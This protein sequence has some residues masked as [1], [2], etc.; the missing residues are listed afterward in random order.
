MQAKNVILCGTLLAALAL[1]A[2]A[3]GDKMPQ[4]MNIRAQS[5]S[6]DEFA[7]L[8]TKPLTMPEDLK[9]LPAPTPGGSNITA[10]T[11]EADAI[12]AL[13]GNPDAV[14]VGD[15]IAAANTGLVSYAARFG[16]EA[17]I[18]DRL[19]QEDLV[20][21]QKHNGRLLER[22]FNINAYFKA[23]Q[24]MMLDTYAELDRWRA[25]GVQTVGAPPQGVKAK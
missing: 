21:R 24:P 5:R 11:P 17:G 15:K 10:P 18:R 9:A 3:R 20:W 19:A 16:R 7:I 22:V 13:G 1:S 12:A 14:K 25:A 23:Y 4:L 8:P 2:C 6:P